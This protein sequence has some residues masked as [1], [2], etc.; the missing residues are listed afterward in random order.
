MRNAN[1]ES[2]KLEIALL[3]LEFYAYH[4]IYEEERKSGNRFSVDL[5]V[6]VHVNKDENF[7][8]LNN[9]IDYEKLY[10]IVKKHMMISSL[11]LEKIAQKILREILEAWPQAISV[12]VSI[13]KFTPPVSG[14]C[15]KAMVTL[16]EER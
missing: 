7:D 2:R 6:E 8:D 14:I 1:C 3:D 13:S 9:T 15:K 5:K 4:G 16:S 12:S 10:A 11:L